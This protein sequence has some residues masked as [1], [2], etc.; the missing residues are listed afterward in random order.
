MAPGRLGRLFSM[1]HTL[2]RWYCA[3]DCDCRACSIAGRELPPQNPPCGMH[4]GHRFNARGLL[5][6]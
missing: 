2:C 1:R 5:I 6:G 3:R 4:V